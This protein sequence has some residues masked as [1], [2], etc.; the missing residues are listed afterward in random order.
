MIATQRE[1]RHARGGELAEELGDA[2]ERGL[3][4]HR[5]DRRVAD[6]GDLAELERRHPGRRMDLAQEPRH[7]ANLGR[8]RAR[9]GAEEGAHVVGHADEG[10]IEIVQPLGERQPHHRRDLAESRPV[11]ADVGLVEVAHR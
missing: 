6:V 2:L 1:R 7:L 11:G 10:D 9:A 3:D 4:V 5:V 8:A